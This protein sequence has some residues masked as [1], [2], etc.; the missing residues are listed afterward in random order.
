MYI[1]D[2]RWHECS[3]FLNFLS[4]HDRIITSNFRRAE[5][6]IVERAFVLITVSMY[7]AEETTT[8]ALEACFGA[9][10][11]NFFAAGGASVFL[12]L[13]VFI[14]ILVVAT[15]QYHGVITRGA[16]AACSTLIVDFIL[17]FGTKQHTVD[18]GLCG[19]CH[20]HR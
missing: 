5:F 7:R 16:T 3:N 14:T 1:V 17:I 10:Q 6:P 2:I 19:V 18:C 20:C 9:S 15:V 8:S 4:N 13:A 11:S 12:L